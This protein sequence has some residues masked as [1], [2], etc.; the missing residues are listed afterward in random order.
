MA[1]EQRIF[2]STRPFSMSTNQPKAKG[3][4]CLASSVEPQSPDTS[5]KG[6]KQHELMDYSKF[7]EVISHGTAKHVGTGP[8]GTEKPSFIAQAEC[9]SLIL[10]LKSLKKGTQRK[11]TDLWSTLSSL[12]R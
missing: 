8:L 10:L 3:H 7:I 1:V 2:N 6:D 9:K 5:G 11:K 12:Y 4:A